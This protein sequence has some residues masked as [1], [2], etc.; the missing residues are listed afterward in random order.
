MKELLTVASSPHIK[1]PDTT[2][3]I[4]SDVIIA[5]APAATYGCILFGCA[6]LRFLIT[7]VSV[8]GAM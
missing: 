3:G 6:P 2:R 7:S 5:L 4:M 8:A 1:R